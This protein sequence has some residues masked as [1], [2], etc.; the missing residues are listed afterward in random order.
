VISLIVV[1]LIVTQLDLDQLTDVLGQASLGWMGLAMVVFLLNYVLRTI[2]FRLL[3]PDQQLPFWPLFSVTALYGMLLYLMPAKSG[4]I[5]FPALLKARLDVDLSESA[6]T[7]VVARFYDFLSVGLFLPLVLAAFWDR[8]PPAMSYSALV[9][10]GLMGLIAIVYFTW[11]RRWSPSS[12][13]TTSKA[14]AGWWERARYWLIQVVARLASLSRMPGQGRLLG[15]TVLIWLA[16]YTNFYLIAS[17][18]GFW[19]AFGQAVILSLLMVP[20]TLLPLQ[21]IANLGSHEIGWTAAFSIFGYPTD[22]AL[23]VTA[24]SHVL[25]LLEVLVLGGIGA[26]VGSTPGKTTRSGKE[27]PDA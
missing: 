17:S 24:G 11:L 20:L 23:L 16:V 2:R 13:G 27:K 6:A 14:D 19:M 5:S 12:T 25:L 1:A 21:G 9:F 10:L 15:L 22:Q 3:F 7:L 18:L 26:L 8:L 4:E